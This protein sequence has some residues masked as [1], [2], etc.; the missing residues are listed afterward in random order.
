MDVKLIRVLIILGTKEELGER[1]CEFLLSPEGEEEPA[2]EE[3]EDVEEDGKNEEDEEES[4]SSEEEKKNTSKRG[5][6]KPAKD[7]KS[8][9]R[10]SAGGRPR[11]ATV[12]R[13]RGI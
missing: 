12:G 13:A 6:G 9:L 5:R 11:R 3:E 4:A 8:A 10:T 7:E 1:I 2:E